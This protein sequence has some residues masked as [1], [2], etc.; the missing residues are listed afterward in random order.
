[1][2][3][4]V[5]EANKYIRSIPYN[6]KVPMSYDKKDF[7]K[8]AEYKNLIVYFLLMICTF[9]IYF[10]IQCY[11]LTRLSNED[12]SMTKRS[13]GLQVFLFLILPYVYWIYWAYQTGKRIENILYKKTG[14]NASVAAPSL[15]LSFFGLDVIAM[16]IMQDKINKYVGGI[17][18]SNMDA[19]GLACCKECG[20]YFPNDV[21]ECPNCGSHYEKK[22]FDNIYVR[23]AIIAIL[24]LTLISIISTAASS[25]SEIVAYKA[26]NGLD[27][28][29]FLNSDSDDS[30]DESYFD[31]SDSTSKE[32]TT[33]IQTTTATN[34]QNIP[35]PTYGDYYTVTVGNGNHLNLRT[36]PDESCDIITQLNNGTRLFITDLRS[37]WGKTTYNGTEGWVCI[38]KYGDTYCT[39]DKQGD[40]KTGIYQYG[41]GWYKFTNGTITYNENGIFENEHG[42]W[43]VR[44]SKVD[45]NYTGVAKNQYGEWYVRNGKVDFDYTAIINDNG[46]SYY[47]MEG[48][49]LDG[50]PG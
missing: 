2:P 45:F 8:P 7:R 46:K 23:A 37:N 49:V 13:P 40:G 36:G 5:P 12:E 10:I 30:Y 1:M 48:R 42:W 35:D 44:N 25:C 17:T 41:D 47:V 21:T 29:S 9:G 32:I 39:K 11:R 4:K 26:F 18:G 34:T 33:S 31:A 14:K 38:N 28:F 19:D 6:G 22:F 24:A 16:L 43:F 3:S 20:I 50:P 27:I 15:I